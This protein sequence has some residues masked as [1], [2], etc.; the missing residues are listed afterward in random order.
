MPHAIDVKSLLAHCAQLQ[1]KARSSW[2]P[3]ERPTGLP[4]L[5][6][7]QKTQDRR[8]GLGRREFALSWLRPSC[9]QVGIALVKR[10]KLF[11]EANV[12][13]D[14]DAVRCT[15]DKARAM[16]SGHRVDNLV[17]GANFVWA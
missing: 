3:C 5:Y 11:E 16:A 6:S 17:G 12:T 9:R 4:H 7:C 10:Q 2:L 15:T 13:G 8:A 1:V 14:I